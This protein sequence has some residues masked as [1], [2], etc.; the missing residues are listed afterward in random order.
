MYK[1]FGGAATNTGSAEAQVAI[2]TKRINHISDHLKTNKKD[3]SN[4][5]RLI[6]M[7]G[8][9]KSLLAYLTKNDLDS[10]RSLID[11]LGLRK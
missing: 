3:H 11:K 5:R 4:R 9:R 8:R 7:V 10:Y 6:Q 1:E 2:L